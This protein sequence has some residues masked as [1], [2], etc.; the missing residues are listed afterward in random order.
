MRLLPLRDRLAVPIL[1]INDSSIKQFAENEHVVGQ[2]V[3][4]FY[5][6]I[7]NRMTNGQRLTVFGH[8]ACGMGVAPNC[9]AA[10]ALISVVEVDPATWLRPGDGR[11]RC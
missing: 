10:H 3:L 4:E 11:D 1:V 5:L 9:R 8:G 6:R 2:S 7:T